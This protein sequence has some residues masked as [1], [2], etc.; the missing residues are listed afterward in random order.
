MAPREFNARARLEISLELQCATLIRKLDEDVDRPRAVL[1]R[2]VTTPSIVRVEPLSEGRR[3]PGV[4][5]WRVLGIFEDVANLRD[6][7]TSG[8]EYERR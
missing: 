4:E 6:R 5:V 1:R 8:R 3:Y 2:V 7:R